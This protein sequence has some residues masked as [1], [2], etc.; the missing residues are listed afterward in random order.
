[1]VSHSHSGYGHNAF[2]VDS[3]G[4]G[5]SQRS[6][7]GLGYLGAAT[8][9]GT[10]SAFFATTTGGTIYKWKK[11]AV[12]GKGVASTLVSGGYS[13]ADF[14]RGL[15]YYDGYVYQPIREKHVIRK[16]NAENGADR[17]E[18]KVGVVAPEL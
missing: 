1:M 4:D 3:E 14:I 16:I 7:N 15:S 10:D 9:N 12:T 13:G 11:D 17:A 18:L 8:G 2:V 6:R 5:I